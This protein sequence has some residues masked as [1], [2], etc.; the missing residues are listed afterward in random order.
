LHQ[1]FKTTLALQ[2]YISNDRPHVYG[3]NGTVKRGG[4]SI[5]MRTVSSYRAGDKRNQRN[6]PEQHDI[7]R[8]VMRI[9]A[10]A[11][12]RVVPTIT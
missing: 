10:Y 11:S 8:P 4:T 9:E 2:E 6:S 5:D 1:F 7:I 12:S 3:A